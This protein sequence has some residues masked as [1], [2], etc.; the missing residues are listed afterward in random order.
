MTISKE[1]ILLLFTML[2][3]GIMTA[4]QC[5]V[6]SDDVMYYCIW[7][8]D[9]GDE[10]TAINDFN[11]IIRSQEVHYNHVNGRIIVHFVAQAFLGIFGKTTFTIINTAA[12]AGFVWLI[13]KYVRID[14]SPLV[15]LSAILF[16]VTVM[17]PSFV[18]C[19]IWLLGAINYLWTAIAIIT[20]LLLFERI[21]KRKTRIKDFLL[22]P[23]CLLIGW[24]HE[25]MSLPL[26]AALFLFCL[27]K[28]HSLR[29]TPAWLYVGWFTVGAALCAFAPSVI[30]RA[31]SE[32]VPFMSVLGGKLFSFAFN[33]TQVHTFWLLAVICLYTYRKQRDVLR[34][35][36]Y[37]RGYLYLTI[38]F[39]L[40]IV[41]ISGVT[42][43]RACFGVELFSMLAILSLVGSLRISDKVTRFMRPAFVIAT[44]LSLCTGLWLGYE[45]YRDYNFIRTQ[46][47]EASS[48]I[49]KVKPALDRNAFARRYVMSPVGFSANT[50]YVAY[51]S[52]EEN[53]RCAAHL[54]HL[55]GIYF[56][57]KDVADNI[58]NDPNSYKEYG[59]D[60][61]GGL[62]VM[63]ISDSTTVNGVTFILG[64][65]N[66][67][68]YKRP[69][70]YKGD[71]YSAPRWVIHNINGRR[72]L[73]FDKPIPKIA[74]RIKD[75]RVI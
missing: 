2:A 48:P 39:C 11:D 17:L 25:G 59:E 23:L 50:V 26:A 58:S 12:F 29:H 70:M 9:S 34:K 52:N 62:M 1:H 46:L 35:Q 28:R 69:F 27:Y 10:F 3:V 51:D 57:P 14:K 40:G 41:A 16:M 65:D 45:N 54:C 71:E 15:T 75:I 66:P 22:A 73:F 56:L 37:E 64:E 5:G 68:L 24:T 13:C 31:A 43:S 8:P 6:L 33:L 36:L 55:P 74:R 53:V 47:S 72:F 42:Q 7:R 18:D 44:I 61:S 30:N 60:L 32:Q 21:I 4:M 49:I 63:Q 19:F 67:P 20:F 38:F